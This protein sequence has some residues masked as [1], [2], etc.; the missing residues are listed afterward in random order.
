MDLETSIKP[1]DDNNITPRIAI[2][3]AKDHWRI[4]DKFDITNR[5]A[6]APIVQK[7][8]RC[9]IAPSSKVTTKVAHR[10]CWL[11]K[12]ISTVFMLIFYLSANKN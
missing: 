2:A 11:I 9:I 3:I 5:S 10:A 4:L 12:E 6:I 7:L 1:K 8:V